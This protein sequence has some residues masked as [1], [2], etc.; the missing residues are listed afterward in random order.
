MPLSCYNCGGERTGGRWGFVD[1]QVKAGVAFRTIFLEYSGMQGSC[2]PPP[3]PFVLLPNSGTRPPP[4]HPLLR[5]NQ[6]V[7]PTEMLILLLHLFPFPYFF[8][9]PL[10]LSLSLSLTHTHT[11]THTHTLTH[12]PERTIQSAC[13]AILEISLQ[14]VHIT[15]KQTTAC[16][17][18]LIQSILKSVCRLCISVRKRVN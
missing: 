18:C 12:A 10:S 7:R 4:P 9:F 6:S 11:P 1:H 3:P 16:F 8:L 2:P 14:N 15:Q 5:V 13:I 17:H